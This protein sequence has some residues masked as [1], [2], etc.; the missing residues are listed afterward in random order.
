MKAK[1]TSTVK[2][3]KDAQAFRMPLPTEV[4]GCGQL[5]TVFL[6]MKHMKSLL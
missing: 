6:R 2:D 5:V 1:D 4:F 3:S